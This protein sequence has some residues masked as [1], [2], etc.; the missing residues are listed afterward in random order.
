MKEFS[1]LMREARMSK[2]LS[3]AA[4]AKK[5][6]VSPSTVSRW[7]RL[8][9]G[10]IGKIHQWFVECERL[11]R[12]VF[13]RHS[14]RKPVE[15]ICMRCDQ[16]HCQGNTVLLAKKGHGSRELLDR[17]VAIQIVGDVPLDCPYITEQTVLR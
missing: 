11:V 3:Q 8:G 13:E 12:M 10:P 7:E 6:K 2:G 17:G 9:D 15:E 16:D 14:E 5:L 4:M 1:A